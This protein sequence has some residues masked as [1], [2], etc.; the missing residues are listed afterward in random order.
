MSEFPYTPTPDAATEYA[1]RYATAGTEPHRR[2]FWAFNLGRSAC[3]HDQPVEAIP[4]ALTGQERDA[5][6]AGWLSRDSSNESIVTG[7]RPP[8]ES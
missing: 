3:D 1:N 8:A 5:W 2:L 4:A 7:G 6:Q